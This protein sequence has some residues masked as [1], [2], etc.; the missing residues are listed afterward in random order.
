MFGG[1]SLPYGNNWEMAEQYY[2]AA[3]LLIEG[4]E[5]ERIEDFRL[6][7]P[8]LYLYR[9]WL[10][11]A[12]KGICGIGRDQNHDL[13]KLSESLASHLQQK[14]IA[15]PSWVSNR[16]L[17]MHNVDRRSTA[18]RYAENKID[19]E[20]YVSLP[21]LRNVMKL[22]NKALSSIAKNG[23]LPPES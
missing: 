7:T 21:H 15:M 1:W 10:E 9:L 11:L 18:F 4:I 14:N 2:D 16:L 6:G 3:L 12:I 13:A 17:E 19:G 8:V 20:V 22:L 5:E 23:S